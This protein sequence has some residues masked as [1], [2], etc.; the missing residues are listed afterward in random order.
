[1]LSLCQYRR[2]VTLGRVIIGGDQLLDVVG[3][4]SGRITQDRLKLMA[5]DVLPDSQCCFRAGWG[6]TDV[7]FVARQ[8]VEKA[9]EHH[10]DL[11][12]LFVDLKKGYDSV[13][14]PALWTVQERLENPLTMISIIG[15]FHKVM[16]VKVI[17]DQEFTESLMYVMNCVKAVQWA[18]CYS[19]CILEQ[20]AMA[21]G[22]SAQQLE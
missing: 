15:S 3:N 21:G 13:P 4:I 14:H 1:M 8:P 12:V 19:T 6:H 16:H 7:L 9:W 11:F 22:V 17:V 10:S 18:L 2:K 20:L 5:E